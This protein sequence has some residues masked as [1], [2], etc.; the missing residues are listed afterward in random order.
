MNI[1]IGTLYYLLVLQQCSINDVFTIHGLWPQ[2]ANGS[3]PQYC[4]HV[5]FNQSMIDPIMSKL[6]TDWHSCYGNN[7]DFWNHEIQK[8]YSCLFNHTIGVMNYMNTTLSLFD[9]V[10]NDCSLGQKCRFC[11]NLD[12]KLQ[13][14]AEMINN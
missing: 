10:K 9:Q 12:F 13:E 1:I 8:H 5:E 2:Y 11:V 14:C 4:H 6:D 3:W 7:F